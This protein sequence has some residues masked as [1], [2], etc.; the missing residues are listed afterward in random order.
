MDIIILSCVVLS[1]Y[2]GY[3]FLIPFLIISS[4]VAAW[5]AGLNDA[6][7]LRW[8]KTFVTRS[9]VTT[10]RCYNS[11]KNRIPLI[12]TVN[13]NFAALYE[14]CHDIIKPRTPSKKANIDAL[15]Q[16]ID[17]MMIDNLSNIP[18]DQ[19]SS[20]KDNETIQLLRD[21]IENIMVNNDVV[22]QKL[23]QM[24]L[25]QRLRNFLNQIKKD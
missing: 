16:K 2:N 19:L 8:R 15:V 3:Y 18:M 14:M 25:D 22:K 12:E 24:Q 10:C 4:H 11:I 23:T 20:V 17:T 1:F 7:K 5:E 6:E 21:K 9:I 13:V